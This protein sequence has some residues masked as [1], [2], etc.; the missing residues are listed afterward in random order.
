MAN[1]PMLR[2]AVYTRKSTDEGLDRDFNSLD[3][4]YE[5]CAAYVASQ[6]HEGWSLNPER[7][8]DGGYSGGSTERPSLKKLLS[9]IA[10]GKIDVVVV[11]KVDR[12]TRSLTDFA[13]IV[14]TFDQ[15]G[16]SFVS[17]TQSFNTTSSMGRLTLNILLSFAQ[18]EREVISERIRDKVA[19]S[20][21]RGMWMG[22]PVPLGYDVA[23]RKLVVVPEDAEMVRN[24]MRRY[25]SSSSIRD[26]L[27]EL[28]DD[29]ITTK[30]RISGKGNAYGGIP[31]KRGALYWLLSNRTYLGEVVH[32]GNI[33][34]GEHKAIVDRELFEAVKLRLADRTNPRSTKFSRRVTSLL[35]GMIWDLNGAPMSPTHTDRKEKRYRYYA[36]HVANVSSGKAERVRAKELEDRVVEALTAYDSETLMHQADQ[37]T[38]LHRINAASNAE[39]RAIFKS[40]DLKIHVG[41]DE[42][43][44]QFNLFAAERSEGQ[45][46]SVDQRVRLSLAR[47]RRFFGNGARLQIDPDNRHIKARDKNL[48]AL[49]ARSFAARHELLEMSE[50]DV[51]SAPATRVR[52]LERVARLSYLD[53]GI[54][55]AIENGS[56][57]EQLSARLLSRIGQLPICWT[58]QR[59]L[60]GFNVWSEK[61]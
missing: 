53:P 2:C 12:L 41:G 5:A 19:A 47:S 29:G 48:L 25:I 55:R 10:D 44:L 33:Y 30:R 50:A 3:A 21:A 23:D 40:I 51:A 59:E 24:I 38:P 42:I 31:F 34:R 17:I 46:Q 11:Y 52:H 6:M 8:D 14:Q 39:L 26:L 37:Q 58:E 27:A 7:Y 56:Q 32:K 45:M 43:D 35:T 60:F 36:T 20:K 4:Q 1:I 22:G 9:D 18:F 15:A 61:N 57:P 54:I 16:C 28:A 49:I 13:Q